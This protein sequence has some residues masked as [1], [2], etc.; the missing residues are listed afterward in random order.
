MKRILLSLVAVASLSM[1]ATSQ[2]AFAQG[3]K[4]GGA[5]P[6]AAANVPTK[7]G[8][9]DMAKVFKKYDKFT[10]L[11]E[12]L[13]AQMS[14]MQN[15]AKGVKAQAE[16]I[17]EEMKGFNKDS[18]EYKAL[19]EKLVRLTSDF[20][21]KAKI[22]APDMAR[23]EAQIFEDVYLE[24]ADVI[25]MYAEFYKYTLVLRFNSDQIDA[26]SPQQLANGLNKLVLYH[27]AQDDITEPVIEYLNRQYAKKGGVAPA[28]GG[29][30]P[31]PDR[32]AAKPG[33]N[34]RN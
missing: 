29:A 21:T 7:I 9:V 6:A 33:A 24:V 27:R 31:A 12:D 10:R 22:A 32:A 1:L 2:T 23:K 28:S 34:S 18:K 11:R 20:D 13:Q 26:D 25:K 16:K 8:L 5:A 19:Q 17:A 4:A 15:E 30:A 3:E 14:Q